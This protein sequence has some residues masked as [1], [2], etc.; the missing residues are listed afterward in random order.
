MADLYQIPLDM[1]RTDKDFLR[2]ERLNFILRMIFEVI[3]NVDGRKAPLAYKNDLGMSGHQITEGPAQTRL[4]SGDYVTKSYFLSTEFGR[5]LVGLLSGT[6]KTPLPIT[7]SVGTPSGGGSGGI[8][9][10]ALLTNLSYAT[11]SHTGFVPATRTISTTGPIAG[12]GD[13][14]S[15]RTFTISQASAG[16]DGYLSSADWNVF[17]NKANALSGTLG[18]IAK[19]TA[20]TTIGDSIIKEAAN[21][22]GIGTTVAPAY[23]LEVEGQIKATL[24]SILPAVVNLVDANPIA[25]DAA[26]G[27]HYRVTITADRTLGNPTN[28]TDGQRLIW[29]IAQDGIGGWAITLDT[30]F[31]IPDNLPDIILAT[32]PGKYSM[33]GAIYNLA[34]DKFVITGFAKEYA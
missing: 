15:D 21:K 13:L 30:K 22:I 1:A 25:T 32:L 17:N 29:E 16:S 4:E 9:N 6:G 3:S 31:V 26:L 7:G 19:F 18:R 28:A 5:M 10:H 34:L 8:T 33:I 20:A 2:W 27:N 24:G 23:K 11:A 12:G 14:S